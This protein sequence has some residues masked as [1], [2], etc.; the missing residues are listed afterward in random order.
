MKKA[1]LLSALFIN[2]FLISYAQW[3][4]SNLSVP[5]DYMGAT[6]LGSKAYFAGGEDCVNLVSKVEIYDTKTGHWTYDS[7]SVARE[8][9]FATTCG[10]KIF[11]AGGVDFYISQAV[12][13]TIDI[14]DTIDQT[15]TVEQ[16]SIPRLQ[17]AVVSHGNKVLFA[18]GTNYQTGVYY[19]VVDIYDVETGEWDTASL[20]IPRVVWWA[21]VGD[22]AIF[23]GGY[24]NQ[25][26]SKRVDIYNFTTDS[27]SIDS[28]S[29]PRAFIGMT[30][31]GNKVLIAGGMVSGNTPSS[32]VD[33]YDA[34]T[35][36]WSTTNL[37]LARAFADNQQAVTACG[38]AYFVGGGKINLNQGYW[39]AAYQV[40][41]IYDDATGTWSVDTMPLSKRVHHAVVAIDNK[42]I[43]AGGYLMDPPYG[44]D[45]AVAI[46]TCPSTH[47]LPEGITFTAQQ[48]IDNF[49]TNF[50]GCSEIEGNVSIF[51]SNITNLNGLSVLNTIG[52]NLSISSNPSLVSL[53]GLGG[54]T[55]IGGSFYIDNNNSLINFEGLEN[56]NSVSGDFDIGYVEYGNPSL[57][58]LDGLNNLDSIGGRLWITSNPQLTDLTGLENLTGIGGDLWIEGNSSLSS[59]QGLDSLN[60]FTINNLFIFGNSNLYDCDIL[61]IC[62]FLNNPNGTI[63]IEDNNSGC[64][65]PEEVQQACLTTLEEAKIEEEIIIIPNPSTDKIT[66]SVPN[67]ASIEEVLIYSQTGQKVLQEK[68]IYN[69]LDIAKLQHG[70]Y[71]IELITDQG[72]IREKLIIQ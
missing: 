23:A 57:T 8:L 30:T 47:C 44:C 28:L 16:L 36:I 46:Y 21:K 5:T 7:L 27:W 18:G 10:S 63:N 11:F 4:F 9:P 53:S 49:Q 67:G 25:Q 64:N 15:W 3:T 33:I 43:I 12:F 37:S 59:L 68:P 20:S 14:Y 26:S 48:Q 29:V 70:M 6:V 52:G 65:N 42:V 22:L 41:D 13:S 50:P 1:I 24:S 62:E 51:M 35:G 72:K 45:A 40:I 60:S 38:K 66:I 54:L 39:T 31:I 71:I 58:S 17:A 34:S 55:S 56:L 61:S 19:D 32:V 2:S 69:T